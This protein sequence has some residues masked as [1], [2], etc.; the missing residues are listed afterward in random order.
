MEKKQRLNLSLHHCA[1]SVS[2]IQRSIE[3]Y[4]RVLGLQVDTRSTT[5]DGALEIV[6]LHN[7]KGHLELFAHRNWRPLPE[8]A[9]S[10]EADIPVVGTKHVAF[11]TTDLL[12][13]HRHLQE[14][15]VEELTDV[16]NNNKHYKYCF[17]KDPDGITVEVVSRINPTSP[18]L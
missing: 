17:F 10:N 4:D 9:Q 14:Q 7:G 2:D 13:V 16:F 5:D 12:A 3:F 6:H 18:P 8:H 15:G 1:L 11:S